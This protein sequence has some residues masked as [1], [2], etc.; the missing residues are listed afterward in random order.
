MFKS[1][2]TSVLALILV[3]TAVI[4]HAQKTV[5]EGTMTFNVV[6]NGATTEIKNKFNGDL[7]RI[8]MQA[9]PALINVISNTATK[10]GLL[11]IDV[12]IAQKQFAVK[13]SKEETEKQEAAMPVFSDFK[14]TGEKQMFATLNAEKYTYKD[15]KGASHELWA[16]KDITIPALKGKGFFK[17]LDAVPVKYTA[18][19]NGVESNMTLKSMSTDKVGAISL[20]V[21]DGYDITTMDELKAMQGG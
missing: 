20:D 2:K 21:P 10:T 5:N 3:A 11:L 19:I 4:A 1:I 7:T 16:T 8:E 17:T 9:G 18:T 12:P 14:A 13:I 6:A 15:D